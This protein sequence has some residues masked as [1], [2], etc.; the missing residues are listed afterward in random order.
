MCMVHVSGVCMSRES[1]KVANVATIGDRDAISLVVIH[2]MDRLGP[3]VFF[4]LLTYQQSL[5]ATI[6][7]PRV[8]STCT[9]PL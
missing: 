4:L 1:S 5:E 9:P 7:M 3:P 8:D 6:V 2:Y